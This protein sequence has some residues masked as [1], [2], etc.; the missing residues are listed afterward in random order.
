MDNLSSPEGESNVFSQKYR[1]LGFRLE[2]DDHVVNLY[3]KEQLVH[4]FTIFVQPVT[5]H[6][7]CEE[8][9][10]NG[11]DINI[12]VYFKGCKY[13]LAELPYFDGTKED[14]LYSALAYSGENRLCLLQWKPLEAWCLAVELED[15]E[16]AYPSVNVSDA[17]IKE[18]HDKLDALGVSPSI[19]KSIANACDWNNP[20]DVQI[21]HE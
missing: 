2:E 14:P 16:A 17:R 11:A 15:L 5:L 6:K 13:E 19:V 12:V 7:C 8:Y 1:D 21:I 3:Y 4:R 20:Y 10:L 9:L 18:L